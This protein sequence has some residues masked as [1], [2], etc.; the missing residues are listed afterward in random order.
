MTPRSTA[1]KT[2]THQEVIELIRKGQAEK[3]LR[4]YGAEIGISSSFLS[5][6]YAGTRNPGPKILKYFGIAKTR[7]VIYE[8]TWRGK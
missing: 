4:E 2:I 6:I 8:Y 7:R 5:D 3:T 1:K